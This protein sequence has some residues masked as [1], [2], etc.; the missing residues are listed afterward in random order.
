MLGTRLCGSKED[1]TIS[2]AII[3]VLFHRFKP[4]PVLLTM[5][6]ANACMLIGTK[7]AIS[8]EWTCQ[9]PSAPSGGSDGCIGTELASARY[10]RSSSAESARRSVAGYGMQ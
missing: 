8:D 4:N 6:N 1:V 2:C 10:Y 7:S 3:H 9:L 5:N